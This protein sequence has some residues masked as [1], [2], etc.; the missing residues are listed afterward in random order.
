V[1][2]L[3]TGLSSFTGFWLARTL[4]TAGH[5]VVASITRPIT[6]YEDPLRQRRLADSKHL[7]EIVECAPFGSEKFLD[8]LST[9]KF[10]LICHH[11]AFV[12]GYRGLEFDISAA[13]FNNTCNIL[14]VARDASR[15]DVAGFVVT[16]S[17]FEQDEGAGSTPLHAFS[18]YGLSKCFSS[19]IIQYFASINN[20]AFGKFVISNP[21]GPLEERRFTAYLMDSWK[22]HRTAEVR[23]PEYVRDNIHVDLLAYEYE[24]FC[25]KVLSG[26]NIILRSVKS[27]PSGYVE[28]QG[29]FALRVANEIRNRSTLECKVE[30]LEQRVFSEPKSRYNTD[31]CAENHPQW[32]ESAAWDAFSAFYI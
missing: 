12:T 15:F 13:I 17:I 8:C 16:G 23:T 7:M 10:D 5:H 20:L 32:N 11:G 1:R 31:A 30:L 24:L 21:F 22:N 27:S 4:V 3:F 25:R 18:P 9:S 6:S 28:S 14:Q 26:S 29:E 2:I 19:E